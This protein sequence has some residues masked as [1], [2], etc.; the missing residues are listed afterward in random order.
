MGDRE[1]PYEKGRGSP[2]ERV[3]E[4]YVPDDV[5]VERHRRLHLDELGV[6]AG[7]S[8]SGVEGDLIFSVPEISDPFISAPLFLPF[9]GYFTYV[10]ATAEVGTTPGSCNLKLNCGA[11]L[12]PV[13]VPQAGT[14]SS[15]VLLVPIS[16]WR[17]DAVTLLKVTRTNLSTA[18]G[19]VTLV[20]HWVKS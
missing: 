19:A 3:R 12:S 8:G 14:H 4:P 9:E 5:N 18:T 6:S 7:V 15:D 20:A 17:F 10:Y 16:A 11:T 1:H 13:V 2:W